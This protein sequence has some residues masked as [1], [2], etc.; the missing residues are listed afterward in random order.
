MQRMAGLTGRNVAMVVHGQVRLW[1]APALQ[2]F[3]VDFCGCFR[4]YRRLSGLFVR[5]CSAGLDEFRER[6]SNR[7]IDL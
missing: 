4:Q 7:L 1:V 5:K 2:E 3:S 6:G